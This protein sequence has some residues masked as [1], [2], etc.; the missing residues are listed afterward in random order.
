M[1][2]WRAVAAIVWKD[3]RAELRTKDIFSSMFVFAL[4]SVIVFN[5]AFELRVP[6]M[7]MVVP[8][9]CLGGDQLCR[10]FGVE[11]GICHRAG[12]G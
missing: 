6:D 2:F 3:I 4:L 9:I 1:S 10:H 7:K 5:F 11:P 8:G 12:Q